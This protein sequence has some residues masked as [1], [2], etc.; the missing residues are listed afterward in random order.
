M[1]AAKI[2]YEGIEQGGSNCVDLLI[3]LEAVVSRRRESPRIWSSRRL[4]VVSLV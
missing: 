2:A 3:G 1:A 4:K